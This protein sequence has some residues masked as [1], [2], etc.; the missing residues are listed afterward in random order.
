M[1]SQK[2]YDVLNDGGLSF[3]TNDAN[4]LML[5]TAEK[6][7]FTDPGGSM[8]GSGD[9]GA[10]ATIA[11]GQDLI[12]GGVGSYSSGV[13]TPFNSLTF[14]GSG[15]AVK[16]SGDGN[17]S[18]SQSAGAR[19]YADYVGA[20][21]TIA[22]E[23]LN[24]S[25]TGSHYGIYAQKNLTVKGDAAGKITIAT[26]AIS[27]DLGF[28]SDAIS[29][30]SAAYRAADSFNVTKDLSGTIVN[31]SNAVSINIKSGTFNISKSAYDFIDQGYHYTGKRLIYG[32][33]AGSITISGEINSYAS[34]SAILDSF[35]AE[36]LHVLGGTTPGG[37]TPSV[38]MDFKVAGIVATQDINFGGGIYGG[39]ISA[40]LSNISL[41]LKGSGIL[42]V[43]N[44]NYFLEIPD[45]LTPRGNIKN[46][47]NLSV[48]GIDGQNI[49]S[50]NDLA[51]EI[52]VNA[53]DINS[54]NIL[55]A[56][57]RATDEINVTGN[58]EGKIVISA[59]SVKPIL[60]D[61]DLTTEFD[62]LNYAAGIVATTIS[63]DEFNSDISINVTDSG[64]ESAYF[65]AFGVKSKYLNAAAI[66]GDINISIT[67][68]T[69]AQGIGIFAALAKG[70]NIYSDITVNHG[71]AIMSMEDL[72]L[73]ISGKIDAEYAIVS[74]IFDYNDRHFSNLDNVGYSRFVDDNGNVFIEFHKND[75]IVVDAGASVKGEI[76]LGDGKNTL[77]INSNAYVDGEINATLGT[78]ETEFVLDGKAASQEILKLSGECDLTRSTGVI[79]VNVANAVDG[80]YKLIN[81]SALGFDFNQQI[82]HIVQGDNKYVYTIGEGAKTLDSGM[83]IESNYDTGS[84]IISFTVSSSAGEARK[85]SNISYQTDSR[86]QN[87][88]VRWDNFASGVS[89]LFNYDI[90]QSGEV[91][92]SN[93]LTVTDNS[94]TV[95]NIGAGQYLRGTVEVVGDSATQV[96]FDFIDMPMDQ[97]ATREILAPDFEKLFQR[98][99]EKELLIKL[100]WYAPD[101]EGSLPVS[102]YEIQYLEKNSASPGN[103]DWDN[104]PAITKFSTDNSLIISGLRDSGFYWRCRAVDVNGNAGAWSNVTNGHETFVHT[105]SEDN[106][107]PQ[108][109]DSFSGKSSF[110]VST[111]IISANIGWKLAKDDSSGVEFYKLSV[112]GSSEFEINIYHDVLITGETV[113]KTLDNGIVITYKLS[114][115]LVEC[116][117]S[118]PNGSYNWSL[119]ISDY[120]GNENAN[121]A[122]GEWAGDLTAPVFASGA[123]S[124]VERRFDDATQNYYSHVTLSWGRASDDSG[125]AA[126]DRYEVVGVDDGGNETIITTI[127]NIGKLS[128]SFDSDKTG[129]YN[130]F[131]RAYDKFGN[132]SATDIASYAVDV[133]PPE[134]EFTNIAKPKITAKWGFNYGALANKV[135]VYDYYVSEINVTLNFTAD[136][137]DD[138]S[139]V[140]YEVELSDNEQFNN[141]GGF[142]TK[143]FTVAGD[144]GKDFSLTLDSD[145]DMSGNAA[146]ILL[147]KDKIYYRIRATDESGNN[148]VWHYYQ[149][150]KGDKFF[151]FEAPFSADE[152]DDK[153]RPSGT[154]KITDDVAPI[155]AKS[156]AFSRS[157]KQATFSWKPA[158]DVFGIKSYSLVLAGK[159]G[160]INKTFTLTGNDLTLK[161]G[162]FY[163]TTNKVTDGI[164]SW[165]LIAYDYSGRSASASGKNFTMDS[166]APTL[167]ATAPTAKVIGLD[168]II[169]WKAATD[170]LSGIDHYEVQYYLKENP[171]DVAKISTTS[172]TALLHN[173]SI[174]DYSYTITAV[175]KSGN[176]SVTT[177]QSYVVAESAAYKDSKKNPQKLTLSGTPARKKVASNIGGSNATDYYRVNAD[178]KGVLI[179]D[180]TAKALYGTNTGVTATLYNAA[181]TKV[182]SA[183]ITTG[184]QAFVYALVDG[185]KSLSDYYTLELKGVNV[186]NILQATVTAER[187]EALLN[188]VTAKGK[189]NY[190]D[191]HVGKGDCVDVKS[192]KLATGAL[193][194]F[195][196]KAT[197]NTSF[198]I[199]KMTSSTDKNG[200]VTYA[201]KAIK[202]VSTKKIA[203]ISS[204][205]LNK[206]TYYITVTSTDAAKGGKSDYQISVFTKGDKTY[207]SGKKAASVTFYTKAD[208]GYNN[209]INSK[210][211]SAGQDK[212]IKVSDWVGF[213]D[214]VDYYKF[215]LTS[216][217]KLVFTVKAGDVAKFVICNASGKALQTTSLKKNTSTKTKELLLKAG[218]YYFSM[219]STTA[220][221]GASVSYSVNSSKSTI[222]PAPT[223][224][225]NSWSQVKETAGL[226]VGDYFTGWVGYGDA[227]DFCKFNKTTG[228]KLKLTFDKATASEISKKELQL[229]VL[230]SKGKAVAMMTSKNS[231]TSKLDLGA[232]TYYIGA[233][234]ANT[235]KVDSNFKIKLA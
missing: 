223:T 118:L 34:I 44:N 216:A 164:Y 52:F 45:E 70:V 61:C 23:A 123:T 22:I 84:G 67:G 75:N 179:W 147:R 38:T 128:Y 229:S 92:S 59:D 91:V 47:G 131:V 20:D 51:P 54:S 28:V 195:G 57:I 202:T 62:C 161:S 85:I 69:T 71:V 206:G 172:T 66:R 5:A 181:G 113:T 114:G 143:R 93:S 213:T 183:K 24:G 167:S 156:L 233:I 58:I 177:A 193:L 208:N 36:F 82:I 21:R 176:R 104:D 25:G 200:N 230:D 72:D 126:F 186:N 53:N 222:F 187:E 138:L 14:T 49:T 226:N 120:A 210:V 112:T 16:F 35:Y 199:S 146:G 73:T 194:N 101:V 135:K 154:I 217:A 174:G 50:E 212:N 60:D 190:S 121:V 12:L 107:P 88:T 228:G 132:V 151:K 119:S 185:E 27:R 139:V 140:N 103:P 89:Y 225:D 117:L 32:V 31:H 175:D 3:Y 173:S 168:S 188:T 90:M 220:S 108:A 13:F 155:A 87:V 41:V 86:D 130:F 78:I 159:S 17:I 207:D 153:N 15:Q 97:V 205:L 144:S 133:N 197:G 43:T 42:Y 96:D 136:F 127:N 105:D 111:G 109:I 9:K 81:A 141:G 231:W 203:S 83:I 221:K 189:L 40:S 227:K 191:T 232:G 163:F 100:K 209:T 30:D 145:A 2:F 219:T 165:K 129:K 74:G 11:N 201:L 162:K 142:F 77:K 8:S 99:P 39:T 65:Y 218:T 116:N 56:G 235:S 148:S 6:E 4:L 157:G 29:Y 150:A 33:E 137:T 115:N 134:G 68:G 55:V 184:D 1:A 80:T 19:S 180:I 160:G 166:T 10:L 158:S 122:S 171:D 110:D 7:Y 125:D 79:S 76:D 170:K 124:K 192:F 204:L 46:S 178:G 224:N 196:F 215:T 198:T 64:S 152:N 63:A 214:A 26:P 102:Y 182:A 95:A 18:F 149:T 234:C 37:R 98:S 169:S 48:I 211:T 94:C 106:T